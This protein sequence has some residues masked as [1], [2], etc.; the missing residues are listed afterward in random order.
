MMRTRSPTP[1][2]TPL[3]TLPMIAPHGVTHCMDNSHRLPPEW[4]DQSAQRRTSG[5]YARSMWPLPPWPSLHVLPETHSYGTDLPQQAHHILDGCIPNS[6]IGIAPQ[7]L[8]VCG[9]L[10]GGA[11][12][13]DGEH[14]PPPSH[15]HRSFRQHRESGE[16]VIKFPRL[17][18]FLH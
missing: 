4:P 17:N 7:D 12:K 13:A 11:R 14:Q 3:Y 15:L 2:Y 6:G 9:C 16:D 18:Q 10:R 5:S 8:G 1:L